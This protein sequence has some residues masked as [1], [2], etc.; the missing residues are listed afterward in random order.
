MKYTK[1]GR[2]G[3]VTDGAKA[4]VTGNVTI[5]ANSGLGYGAV[6]HKNST[7]NVGGDVVVPAGLR[8]WGVLAED[9]SVVTVNGSVQGGVWGAVYASGAGTCVIIHGNAGAGHVV[10]GSGA[11]TVLG[12]ATVT[13]D[14]G[15]SCLSGTYA[16]VDYA[17]KSAAEYEPL[18]GK[19][20][21]FTYKN[22][23]NA[24]NSA[25]WVKHPSDAAAPAI[26]GPTS[27]SLTEGYAATSTDAY[28]LTGNPAATVTKVSGP[29][30]IYWNAG[31]KTL[32]ITEGLGKGTHNVVLEVANGVSTV[33][34]KLTFTLTVTAAYEPVT[35]VSLD[36]SS[37]CL[38]VGGS[39]RLTA[40]AFPAEAT[41]KAVIWT[42]GDTGV[43]IV[44]SGGLVT[45][46]GVGR[47]TITAETVDGGLTADCIVTVV[48]VDLDELITLLE[49]AEGYRA[50]AAGYTSASVSA[51]FAAMQAGYAVVDA[52]GP[53]QDDVQDVII[54]LRAAISGLKNATFTCAVKSMLAKVAKL[55]KIPYTWN[56]DP[57]AITFTTSNPAICNVTP[58]GTLVP[59]KA[60]AA[61]ITITAPNGARVVFAVTVSV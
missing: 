27:M 57:S 32:Y 3:G 20:G 51:L 37:I 58:D 12:A 53:T 46:I 17:D 11:A 48:A 9:G 8:F 55:Q 49:S 34:V 10:A 5:T 44:D 54:A 1:T 22:S 19:A 41:N 16:S 25:V 23:Y 38:T 36:I 40:T 45:A 6:L 28:T 24:N 33:P 18:T 50:D 4:T 14:G 61:V 15:L 52:N 35:G 56:A 2:R 42:S 31:A 7:L 21:Y 39:R 59:L 26:S 13:I 47:A 30:Q 29:T 43:A 60:G